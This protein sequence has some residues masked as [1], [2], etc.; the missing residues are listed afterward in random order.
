MGTVN[1]VVYLTSP[2]GDAVTLNPGDPVPEWAELGEHVLV[3]D[4]SDSGA[5]EKAA[6]EAAEKEAAEKAAAEAGG[7]PEGDPSEDWKGAQLDAYA[8]AKGVDLKGA[9]TKA[10]KVAAI[11]GKA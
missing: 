11:L 5:A 8:Q 6:A 3:R 2:E 7:F 1:A 10:E 4:E 9:A